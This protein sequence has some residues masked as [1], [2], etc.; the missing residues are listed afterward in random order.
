MNFEV[1]IY[2]FFRWNLDCGTAALS[3]ERKA[4]FMV[5]IMWY[6]WLL[7][8]DINK[9]WKQ[10]QNKKCLKERTVRI[11]NIFAKN[12]FWHSIRRVITFRIGVSTDSFLHCP[13][14]LHLIIEAKQKTRNDI[15]FALLWWILFYKQIDVL[16]IGDYLNGGRPEAMAWLIYCISIPK[17]DLGNSY[18]IIYKHR[19]RHALDHDYYKKMFE[20]QYK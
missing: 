11:K 15:K 1:L 12:C 5:Y 9:K 13:L 7:T 14:Q 16:N 3:A 6:W 19:K 4:R 10:Q 2:F 18:N 20:M 8:I 17:G